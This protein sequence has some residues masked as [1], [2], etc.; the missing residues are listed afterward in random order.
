M[1]TIFDPWA[2]SSI[3]ALECMRGNNRISEDSNFFISGGTE[4]SRNSSGYTVVFSVVL[5]R[6][7]NGLVGELFTGLHGIVLIA[8]SLDTISVGDRVNTLC[9]ERIANNDDIA[10]ICTNER[11]K[12][13][14]VFTITEI[15]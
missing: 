8:P 1:G 9:K 3:L 5:K 10:N 15:Y 13:P 11:I 12:E 2:L 6:E 4:T 14:G 7:M